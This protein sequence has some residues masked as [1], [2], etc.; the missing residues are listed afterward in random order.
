M[1]D[2]KKG[3]ENQF[4]KGIIERLSLCESITYNSDSKKLEIPY[5]RLN[6]K[7]YKVG[8][9]V[10]FIRFRN[11]KKGLPKYTSP[12]KKVV[13]EYYTPLYYPKQLIKDYRSDK[14][15]SYSNTIVLTEG[16]FKA[17]TACL[18]GVACVSFAG[19]TLHA[20][21]TEFYQ[22][23]FS[24]LVDRIKHR[25]VNIVL[26]YDADAV[27]IE[28]K[29]GELTNKRLLDFQQSAINFY[30]VLTKIP[31]DK[32]LNLFVGHINHEEK[33][34]DDLLNSLDHKERKECTKQL[35]DPISTSKLK[36]SYFKL[37]KLNS[38]NYKKQLNKMFPCRK[39]DTFINSN[40]EQ[41]SKEYFTFFHTS[42]THNTTYPISYYLQ[43]I[44]NGI[45]WAES[46]YYNEYKRHIDKYVKSSQY[47]E[48]LSER[49]EDVREAIK[50]NGRVLIQAPTGA[51]K[52]TLIEKL[53]NSF[54]R[55]ILLTPT[56]AIA[57]QQRGYTLY[58]GGSHVSDNMK[59][60]TD[61]VSTF[62]KVLQSGMINQHDFDNSLIVI[63]EAHEMYKSF[64]YRPK[65]CAM[66]EFLSRQFKNVLCLSATPCLPFFHGLDFSLMTY[67][68][69]IPKVKRLDIRLY[70]DR[71]N[72]Q[73]K[74]NYKSLILEAIKA[75]RKQG[76]KAYIFNLSKD[77]HL[78]NEIHESDS[79]TMLIT[80]ETSRN[81]YKKVFDLILK[82]QRAFIG[83]YDVFL[84]NSVL[85]AGAS[86][87]DT[88]TDIYIIGSNDESQIIQAL[89]RFRSLEGNSFTLFTRKKDYKNNVDVPPYNLKELEYECNL[90]KYTSLGKGD[91]IS[92]LNAEIKT[93]QNSFSYARTFFDFE[94]KRLY[95]QNVWQLIGYLVN[96]TQIEINSIKEVEPP[97]TEKD[98]QSFAIEKDFLIKENALIEENIS[99]AIKSIKD[100]RTLN[101][102]SKFEKG[103]NYFFDIDTNTIPLDIKSNEC[104]LLKLIVFC[105]DISIKLDMIESNVIKLL[106]TILSHF[107]HNVESNYKLIENT[108]LFFALKNNPNNIDQL[109]NKGQAI[110]FRN[111]VELANSKH[112]SLNAYDLKKDRFF[113]RLNRNQRAFY[114]KII[115]LY[116]EILLLLIPEKPTTKKKD[117]PSNDLYNKPYQGIRK[118]KPHLKR[119]TSNDT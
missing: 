59:D 116:A 100:K 41:L 104:A 71:A 36:D 6:G 15:N 16:E 27:V 4:S 57:K 13:G 111:L 62:A 95:S 12:S 17:I 43:D 75:T 7:P 52:T 90:D 23:E 87:Y 64:G 113:K 9:G 14:L 20:H 84:T 80:G 58:I 34:I 63:D 107:N 11:Y 19:I 51:G 42:E 72:K 8:K 39:L 48:Y 118:N 10:D 29:K 89:S 3:L 83:G 55:V 35:K 101:S 97:R 115:A 93:F 26:L 103:F 40:Q 78:I 102:L 47:I 70:S 60:T 56:R 74:V 54:E 69:S 108:I 81:K 37:L 31:T 88:D 77:N 94:Q 38:S 98:S 24:E 79:N 44:D 5:H 22:K 2:N 18:C 21:F 46:C 99:I 82:N 45:M 28:S 65:E 112:T 30:K 92:S 50:E 105:K 73:G 53:K 109:S 32:K 67:T 66:L 25:V 91:I 119:L 110:T 49:T 86:F 76:R 1:Q 85:E 106:N 114:L 96:S 33:G 117:M 68:Q 61:I